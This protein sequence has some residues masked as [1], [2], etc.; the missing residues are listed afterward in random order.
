MYVT[1]EID[2]E[3]CTGCRLC[4]YACPDPNVLIFC[5]SKKVAVDEKRCKGCGL[6]AVACPNKAIY[7]K[8]A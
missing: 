8:E 1:A 4:I 7:V 6:C 5:E 2:T 3:K